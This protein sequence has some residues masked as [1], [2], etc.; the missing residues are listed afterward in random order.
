MNISLCC[1]GNWELLA[2]KL[3][4][5]EWRHW[6]E[7]AHHPFEVIT[8]HKNIEYMRSAK[9]LNPHQA[10]WVLFFTQFLF[11]IIYRSGDKNIKVDSLSCIH[12]PV[13]APASEP[14]LP[15]ALIVSP[16]QWD[17][18]YQICVATLSELAPPGSQEGKTYIPSTLR[19][20]LLGLLHASPGS[21]HPGSQRSLLPLQARYWW[22]SMAWEVSQFVRSCSVCAITKTPHHLPA[23]KLI[24]L[25]I[26]RRPW[27]SEGY[28]CILVA[29]KIHQF[30]KACK[31]TGSEQESFGLSSRPSPTGSAETQGLCRCLPVQRPYLSPRR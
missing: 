26:P 2:I 7:G 12:S 24:L 15:P 31:L 3:V 25:L 30:S 23:G 8:D 10:R 14:I 13:E 5:E 19:P 18:Q 16:I 28:T 4:L 29:G 6:L 9:R 21:G 22:P 1:M 17:L 27:Y 20:T 11:M